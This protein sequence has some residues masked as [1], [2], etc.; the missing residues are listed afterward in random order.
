M[1][2]N[3]WANPAR[4]DICKP[5]NLTQNAIAVAAFGEKLRRA[6]KGPKI[7][8]SRCRRKLSLYFVAT[9]QRTEIRSWFSP[10]WEGVAIKATVPI[11]QWRLQAFKALFVRPKL[12]QESQ[13]A[14]FP[15]I[16]SGTA[17]F[18]RLW[19][20]THLLENGANPR[21]IQRY[22]GHANLETTMAYFHLTQK[23][24]EDAYEI[25]NNTMKGFNRDDDN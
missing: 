17:E 1:E 16:P 24:M 15:F 9:G 19:R 6:T 22:M 23:G 25:I 3:G 5:K 21:I 7:A 20:T 4:P 14:V 11:R 2:S 12:L 8:M 13:N 10:P 18:I